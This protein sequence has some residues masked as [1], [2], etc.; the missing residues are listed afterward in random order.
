[1]SETPTRETK[2]AD[3]ASQIRDH[4]RRANL[5]I[6]TALAH[7][8]R[9][10]Q[11]LMAAKAVL[12]HGEYLTWVRH[13]CGISPRTAQGYARIAVNWDAIEGA[14]ARR[15]AHSEPTLGVREAL[16]LL[17]APSIRIGTDERRSV[18]THR[19][20]SCAHEWQGVARPPL[21]PHPPGVA[22]AGTVSKSGDE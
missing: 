21:I 6:R 10:G 16:R 4:H 17:A 14:N 2:L 1:V 5:A 11:L 7:A 9:V 12:P 20:P 13:D 18:S 8:C 19:C 3:L 15:V 22:I